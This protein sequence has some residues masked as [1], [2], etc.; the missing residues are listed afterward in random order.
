[1][2]VV[3]D[4]SKLQ[5]CVESERQLVKPHVAGSHQ[6]FVTVGA[7]GGRTGAGGRHSG[8]LV[9][10]GGRATPSRPRAGR[11]AAVHGRRRRGQAGRPA[12]HRRGD[13]RRQ[14]PGALG[15][16]VDAARLRAGGRRRRV[17]H[18][19]P[20]ADQRTAGRH[21]L[22]RLTQRHRV[23]YRSVGKSLKRVA[24][25][26]IKRFLL[27]ALVEHVMKSVVSVCLFTL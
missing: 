16:D 1:M 19:C 17:D 9:G 2:E 26:E 22:R 15:Q 5:C 7:A 8:V 13:A 14:V 21:S 23:V 20:D 6:H 10:R 12:T 3:W 11:G 18:T 27:T 24:P 25:V 4:V